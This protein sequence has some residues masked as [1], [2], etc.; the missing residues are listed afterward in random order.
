VRV[1]QPALAPRDPD[2]PKPLR[3]AILA[4]IAALVLAGAALLARTVL[5]DRYGSI[6]EAALDLRLPVLGEV[7]KD[8]LDAV[9]AVE[10][11][12][13]LR[14]RVTHALPPSDRS[15][16]L[17]T[18]PEEAT[19]KSHVVTGLA[20]SLAS[21]G[22]SVVAIDADLRRPV[23]HD[24]LGVPRTPGLADTLDS[25]DRLS[26]ADVMH[27]VPLLPA[28]RDRGGEL[29][30][31]PAGRPLPD[32]AEALSG[33]R[34]G[35]LVDTLLE[36][37]DIAVLD[38]PP[39]LALADAA[40]VSRQA[41]AVLLV[42]DLKRSHRRAMRRAVQALRSLDAPLLGLVHNRAK[43]Q[44]GSYGYYAAEPVERERSRLAT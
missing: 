28:A 7:P 11:F 24:R 2:A 8:E 22:A 35:Q 43:L 1:I 27:P 23:I 41:G 25:R 10:A 31:V 19:G 44:D 15:A 26:L 38:S 9:P 29:V 5:G 37:F 4:A 12:R 40:V 21:D 16:V 42:V 3:N 30:A 39:V 33:P 36:R 18:S 32:S 20:R 6:E 14:T 34:M 13:K 17:I